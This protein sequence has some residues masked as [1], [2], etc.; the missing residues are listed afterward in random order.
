MIIPDRACNV[1]L[2]FKTYLGM[3]MDPILLESELDSS[4][5][6]FGRNKF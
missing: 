5:T 1:I 4:L 2:D 3:V 6:G